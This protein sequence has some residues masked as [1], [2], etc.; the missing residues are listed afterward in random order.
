MT[1]LSEKVECYLAQEK[2]IT[3]LNHRDDC[4]SDLEKAINEYNRGLITYDRFSKICE[5]NKLQFFTTIRIFIVIYDD[6]DD[7]NHH[8]E[9]PEVIYQRKNRLKFIIGNYNI[10]HIELKKAIFSSFCKVG[11]SNIELIERFCNTDDIIEV[12]S[13]GMLSDGYDGFGLACQFGQIETVKFLVEN[14]ESKKMHE[15]DNYY[16]IRK[17]CKNNHK[18]VEKYLVEKYGKCPVA[19]F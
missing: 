8:D 2:K 16:G 4:L 13:G 3:L 17:A 18:N 9:I 11:D 15:A 12:I 14:F 19:I 5:S 7:A 10:L 6:I 1:T